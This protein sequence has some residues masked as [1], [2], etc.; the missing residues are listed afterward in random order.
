[1][2][3]Y[4]QTVDPDGPAAAAGVKVCT[5]SSFYVGLAVVIFL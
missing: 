4:V 2:P 5:E 3:V 1:M